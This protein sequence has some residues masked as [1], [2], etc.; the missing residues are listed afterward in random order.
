MIVDLLRND[1]GRVCETGSIEVTS[2][3]DIERYRTVWQMTSDVRGRLRDDV[4]L[5]GLF[6]ALFPCGSVT[7]APKISTMAEIARLETSP[8][9]AYCGAIG[10]VRPGGDC[11]FSVPIRTAWL[12]RDTGVIEYGTGGGVVWD[13]TAE[14]EYGELRA[15]A[16]VIREPWPDFALLETL[17][18][19]DG[20]AIRRDRH[21]ARM[22]ASAAH[23]G[24]PFP[25]PRLHDALDDLTRAHPRG[26]V[27]ARITLD[28]R[29]EV[30][31]TTEPL[32]MTGSPAP[33]GPAAAGKYA[34]G[35]SLPAVVLARDPVDS[36]SLFLYHK[37]TNRE[38]YEARRRDLPEGALDALLQ[39]EH[40]EVTEFTRGNLVVE[41]DGQLWTPP[42]ESGLLPGCLRQEL[43]DAGTIR[44]RVILSEELLHA[45]RLWFINSARGWIEVTPKDR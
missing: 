14:G 21:L 5:V 1:L 29:G 38:I 35:G 36:A 34:G 16:V 3:H 45:T 20:R 37:T 13:S 27:R 6:D 31:A 10:W 30:M 9:G 33:P 39:N 18:I 43:L 8:R 2:L 4:G 19:R 42:R 22:R 7:G 28:A 25:A 24:Y 17:A 15:K 11:T 32:G 44:E 40:G 26:D 23:L 41:I 12:D